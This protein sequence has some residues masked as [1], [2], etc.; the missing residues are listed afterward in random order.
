MAPPNLDNINDDVVLEI[1][2]WLRAIARHDLAAYRRGH[3]SSSEE[4][5]LRMA[6]LRQAMINLASINMRFRKILSR[7]LFSNMNFQKFYKD[8]EVLQLV[9]VLTSSEMLQGT[10]RYW[11]IT[12]YKMFAN[13]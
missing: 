5:V 4:R 7:R 2:D 10:L 12:V 11:S 6:R 13:K 1:A 9:K 8:E 3:S